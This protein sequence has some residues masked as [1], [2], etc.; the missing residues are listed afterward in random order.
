VERARIEKELGKAK[1]DV[2]FYTKRLGNEKFVQ[3]AAPEVIA[4]DRAALAES[5][6]AMTTLQRALEHL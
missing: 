6:A 3:N 2:D 1:K 4:K 5:H